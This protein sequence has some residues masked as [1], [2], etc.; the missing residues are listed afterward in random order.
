MTKYQ[1]TRTIVASVAVEAE[2]RREAVAK[3]IQHDTWEE[4]SEEYDAEEWE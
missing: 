1:V 4:D 2:N 3:A